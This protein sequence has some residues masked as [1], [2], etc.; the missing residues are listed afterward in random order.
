MRLRDTRILGLALAWLLMAGG[1]SAQ[2]SQPSEY[3]LK[4]A[5]LFNFA[6][7]VEWPPAAFAEP[8]SPLII[9]ILGE[10]PFG[11]VLEETVRGKSLNNHPLAV[12]T[13]RS[14]AE[15]TNCH[16]LFISASEADRLPAILAR[17]KGRSILTVG[18]TKDFVARDGI[19]GFT[20][21]HKRLKLRVNLAAADA[22]KLTISSKLLRQ[23]DVVRGDANR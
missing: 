10:N 19:V 20:V 2:D 22:A 4:A 8:N 18:D 13:F 7:F 6:K 21:D 14:V 16:V 5:F 1:G 15:S 11:D 12:R 3:Q 9:G 23:A 17:L